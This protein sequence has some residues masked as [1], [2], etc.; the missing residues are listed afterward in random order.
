[1]NMPSIFGRKDN[2]QAKVPEIEVRGDEV[3]VQD[4]NA[5]AE[6]NQPRR[7]YKLPKTKWF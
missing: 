7:S 5:A 2:D 4:G 6:E 3:E 1:M